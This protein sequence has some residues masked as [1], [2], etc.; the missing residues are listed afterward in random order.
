MILRPRVGGWGDTA[1]LV[2]DRYLVSRNGANCLRW[3]WDG[4]ELFHLA[5]DG[6]L[7]AVPITLSSTPKV[8]EATP[9][10]TIDTQARAA[11]TFIVDRVGVSGDGPRFWFRL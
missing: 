4:K 6:E 1:R 2:G 11:F 3:R 7:Y 9:L 10:F 5:W 8:G